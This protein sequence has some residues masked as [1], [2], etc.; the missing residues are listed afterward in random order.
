MLSVFEGMRRSVRGGVV[1]GSG[2]ASLLEG[3]GRKPG[4]TI[5]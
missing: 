2:E 5:M 1:S 3:K 4:H